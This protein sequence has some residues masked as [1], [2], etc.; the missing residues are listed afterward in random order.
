MGVGLLA[1]GVALAGEATAQTSTRTPTRTVTQT[2][3]PTDTRTETPTHTATVTRTRTPTPGCG[4]GH[5]DEDAGEVCDDGDLLGGDG[6]SANCT[7]ETARV[8]TISPLLSEFHLQ[9]LNAVVDAGADELAAELTLV[10]GD[11]GP[12]GRI[13]VAIPAAGVA[14]APIQTSS[15]CTCIRAKAAPER[16]GAGNA[17]GGWIGC[18]AEG[19]GDVDALLDQDHST[20]D[21]DPSCTDT[22]PE[23]LDEACL[24]NEDDPPACNPRSP[25]DGTCNGPLDVVSGGSGGPGS[26]AFSISLSISFIASNNATGGCTSHPGDPAYGPDGLACTADDP[27]Q[28]LPRI[29]PLSTG[30]LVSRIQ[31]ANDLP[32]LTIGAGHTCGVTP[33]ATTITGAPFDCS[34]LQTPDGSLDGAALA[35]EV[36]VIDGVNAGDI[37]VGYW[38][39]T[40]G[41]PTVTPRATRTPTETRTPTI[42]QSPSPTRTPTVT[43]TPTRTRTV[44]QTRT[45]QKTPTP[46]RTL[47]ATWTVRATVTRTPSRTETAA[48]TPTGPT[49]TPTS[50]RTQT[51]TQP[52]PTRTPTPTISPTTTPTNSRLPTRTPT[53]TRTI[54][55]TRTRTR[56]FTPEPELPTPTNTAPTATST[57]TP[58]PT[59]TGPSR[60]PTST[61]TPTATGSP[62]STGLATETPTS[63]PSATATA[64][65]TA[66]RTATP[67]TG[68]PLTPT[69]TATSAASTATP[70]APAATPTSTSTAGTSPTPT[71]APP[72]ATPTNTTVASPTATSPS[73]A[74]PTA[75][76]I[77]TA[78]MTP[79][80]S[81]TATP[82]GIALLGDLNHDGVVNGADMALLVQAIFSPQPPADADVNH[83]GLV[84][85]ADLIAEANAAEAQ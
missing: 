50:T 24:E 65:A 39:N 23:T 58:S 80:A 66:T 37:A 41:G 72:D 57:S 64:L 30:M 53:P 61:G 56:T 27:D 22:N 42:V 28:R 55:P 70:T 1:L 13:G 76:L 26:A 83:D 3:E 60:T 25:H 79:L 33:C 82:T 75:T 10:T 20:E 2:S 84:S 52:T 51:P 18:G 85:A 21:I 15:V 45:P 6:C 68:V 34:A 4:D 46:T 59:E 36:P 40:E 44:T 67:T 54:T 73:T 14:F 38:L 35:L 32:N 62:T 78:T 29:V 71:S 69:A 43:R 74:S 9:T 17:G 81:A 19:L 16:F 11:I 5:V 7:L 77:S 8:F 31:D 47:T 12:D 48:V 63:T 49:Q